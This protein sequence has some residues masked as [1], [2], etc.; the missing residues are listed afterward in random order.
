M[1]LDLSEPRRY[2]YPTHSSDEAAHML[3]LLT[4]EPRSPK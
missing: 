1:G 3:F 4:A 2:H